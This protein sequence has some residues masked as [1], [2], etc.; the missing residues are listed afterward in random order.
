MFF[1]FGIINSGKSI[2][3]KIISF[4]IKKNIIDTDNLLRNFFKI[5]QKFFI[6]K[7]NE[8]NFRKIENHI[9]RIF[10]NIDDIISPGGG[11]GINYK[12]FLVILKLKIKLNIIN[13]FKVKIKKNFLKKNSFFKLVKERKK[14]NFFLKIKSFLNENK[15]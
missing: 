12:S 10:N 5:K 15:K 13:K 11:G 7:K 6:V 3:S 8:I 2:I 1:L 9:L 14:N 4:Y